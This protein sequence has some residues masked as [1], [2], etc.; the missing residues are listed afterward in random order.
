M[1]SYSCFK[2][3]RML[4]YKVKVWV[5]FHSFKLE[6]KSGSYFQKYM[7]NRF[8]LRRE[9][10]CN[11]SI[12]V[13]VPRRLIFS[14]PFIY[15]LVAMALF[16]PEKKRHWPKCSLWFLHF[17]SF[18]ALQILVRA[19]LRLLTFVTKIKEK[20]PHHMFFQKCALWRDKQCHSKSAV[21]TRL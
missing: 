5:R 1:T 16:S 3:R 12:E 15:L 2:I 19:S 8:T 13:E 4:S 7:F 20:D 21:F 6:Q 17:Y 9:R 14:F 11:I 10:I 18:H